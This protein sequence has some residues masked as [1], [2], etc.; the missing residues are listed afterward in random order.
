MVAM[1]DPRFKAWPRF[2]LR[3]TATRRY[4]AA[5]S[6]G[7][8]FQEEAAPKLGVRSGIQDRFH[9]IERLPYIALAVNGRLT[10]SKMV[11]VF[12]ILP[13]SSARS[14]LSAGTSTPSWSTT[15]MSPPGSPATAV[16]SSGSVAC[17]SGSSSTT[18]SA[19]SCAPAG[20]TPRCSAPTPSAPKGYGFKID[21][22]PPRELEKTG[23]VEAGVK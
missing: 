16:P 5:R 11:V 4:S 3:F 8:V 20:T 7:A 23:R 12:P 10:W 22:C 19:R 9:G 18:P 1:V 21:P 6:G 17:L 15:R 13:T 14:R 2:W